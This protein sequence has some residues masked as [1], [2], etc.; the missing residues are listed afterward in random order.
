MTCSFNNECSA[1]LGF[2]ERSPKTREQNGAY[3]TRPG[4]SRL[5]RD[6]KHSDIRRMSNQRTSWM[7][8]IVDS[9]DAR[10]PT[11]I[12][13]I[14]EEVG[15]HSFERSS[16]RLDNMSGAGRY[17]SSEGRSTRVHVRSRKAAR[18][19]I[20]SSLESSNVLESAVGSQGSPRSRGCSRPSA[21]KTR[22]TY[23]AS[24][25]GC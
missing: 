25:S 24:S 1:R 19:S 8:C 4:K 5:Y 6:C 17:Q 22:P 12:C 10:Y 21:V 3:K 14:S 11:D 7:S 15:L 16:S 20:S 2:E 18:Q 9:I 13:L 23:S